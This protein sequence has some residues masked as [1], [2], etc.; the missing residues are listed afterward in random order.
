MSRLISRSR[1]LATSF[2]AHERRFALFRG[3][4]TLVQEL[5]SLIRAFP[6]GHDRFG[7]L[8]N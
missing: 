1:Q 4:A 3:I 6:E 5:G 8:P 7:T 2:V